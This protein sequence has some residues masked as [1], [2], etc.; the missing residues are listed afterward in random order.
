MLWL[1]FFLMIWCFVG[2]VFYKTN[3]NLS[4]KELLKYRPQNILLSVPVMWLLLCIKSLDLVMYVGALYAMSGIMYS[5][6]G[7]LAVN[8]VGIMLMSALEYFVGR[9]M[10]A[11]ILDQLREKYPKLRE[12]ERLMSKGTFVFALLLR[13]IG[14]PLMIVGLYFGARRDDFKKYFLGSCLGMVPEMLSF[15]IMGDGA[16][17]ES[18]PLLIAAVTVQVLAVMFSVH[19]YRRLKRKS[20]NEK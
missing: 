18:L 15:T 7:A 9:S 19:Y 1:L 3:G 10:G 6:A 20:E 8:A 2:F 13:L 14:L 17:N 5:L 4:A 12:S 16:A 11:D